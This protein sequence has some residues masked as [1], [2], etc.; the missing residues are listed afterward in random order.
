MC[1]SFRYILEDLSTH[2]S[3]CS[4]INDKHLPLDLLH[5]MPGIHPSLLFSIV[6]VPVL[7]LSSH[8]TVANCFSISSCLYFISF[9]FVFISLSFPSLSL[10]SCLSS[11]SYLS[12]HFVSVLLFIATSQ[13][14]FTFP[15]FSVSAIRCIFHSFI[16]SIFCQ[17]IVSF[18]YFYSFYRM[19]SSLQGFYNL[20]SLTFLYF[21]KIL[22]QLIFSWFYV[23]TAQ[24]SCLLHLNFS[25]KVLESCK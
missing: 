21:F 25:F 14:L 7:K 22:F 1:W 5:V 16:S 12:I 8:L 2:P 10:V 3:I 9:T 4:F 13:F 24:D 11:I 15:C 17:F 19:W 23:S 20:F 18:I 6:I